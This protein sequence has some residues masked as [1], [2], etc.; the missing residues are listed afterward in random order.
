MN[1]EIDVN[2]HDPSIILGTIASE[3]QVPAPTTNFDGVSFPH[4]LVP[5]SPALR[6]AIAAS[7]IAVGTLT[8][9][10]EPVDLSKLQH[11][12]VAADLATVSNT[13]P[14][15]AYMKLR[16]AIIAAG[17]PLLADE[18]LRQEIRDRKGLTEQEA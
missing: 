8:L 4:T 1:I 2:T 5:D 14:A 10:S 17:I 11:I 7:V 16:D 13:N 18:E 15:E 12:T 3:H 9:G 6:K